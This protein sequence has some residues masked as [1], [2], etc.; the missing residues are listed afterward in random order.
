MIK[1][2]KTSF[3][4]F[5]IFIASIFASSAVICLQ[6]Y[7]KEKNNMWLVLSL[8]SYCML[9]YSYINLFLNF[10]IVIVYPFVKIISILLV[11]LSSLLFFNSQLN[12]KIGFGILFGLISVYLLSEVNE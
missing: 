7:T 12:I 1:K 9:M 5:W 8:L 2:Q 4:F 3:L 6:M 11:V 10:N